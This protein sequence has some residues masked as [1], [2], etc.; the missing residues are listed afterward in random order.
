MSL[1]ARVQHRLKFTTRVLFNHGFGKL[2]DLFEL[3]LYA[4][5]NNFIVISVRSQGILGISPVLWGVNVP[6]AKTQP[7]VAGEERT[8]YF[9]CFEVRYPKIKKKLNA[10]FFLQ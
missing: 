6:C 9:S 2:F 7:G 8:P 10:C 5:V 3:M 4:P 1:L